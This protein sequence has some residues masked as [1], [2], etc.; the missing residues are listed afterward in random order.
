M[1]LDGETACI[2]IFFSFFARNLQYKQAVGVN[3][4]STF[5]KRAECLKN[6]CVFF[7]VGGDL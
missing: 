5:Y 7:G 6:V 1:C 2:K 4:P 3:E